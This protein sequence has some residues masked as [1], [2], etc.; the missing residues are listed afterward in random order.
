MARRLHYE[1]LGSESQLASQDRRL[2]A[3][4][5]SALSPPPCWRGTSHFRRPLLA[6]RI[7]DF[8]PRIPSTRATFPGS[9]YKCCSRW[10]RMPL[11]RSVAWAATPLRLPPLEAPC[12]APANRRF[13]EAQP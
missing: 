1:R 11:A 2:T 5:L 6:A 10:T 4:L 13:A 7:Q 3:V 9:R 8:L 12:G